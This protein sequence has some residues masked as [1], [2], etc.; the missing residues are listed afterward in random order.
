MPPRTSRSLDD[1]RQ[2]LVRQRLAAQ[3]LA[4][5]G[6]AAPEAVVGWFGAVQAQEYG[7]ARWALGQRLSGAYDDAALAA[8]FDDGRLL[9]T[10][11]LR[12]T[13]HFVTPSDLRWMLALTGPRIARAMAPYDRR[14]EIDE[15]LVGRACAV[16]E[17]TLAVAPHC[18]RAELA[19]ALAA[20]GIAASGQR[21]AHLV[22]HAELRAVVCSGPRRG[23]QFTYALVDQRVPQTERRDE[24]EA[25]ATLVQR[26]FQSHGPATAR[27]F[28]WWSG[29][30]IADATRMLAHLRASSLEV[31]GV[32]YWW[33]ESDTPPDH[34]GHAARAGRA[35]RTLVGAD[36]P[37]DQPAVRLLPIYDEYVVAYRD[38]T[39]VPHPS[40]TPTA[41]GSRSVVFQHALV[42]DGE[43]V[44]TWRTGTASGSSVDVHP[45]RRLSRDERPA[46]EAAVAR[47]AQFLGVPVKLRVTG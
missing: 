38:R 43:I 41:P 47:Y 12:P 35:G 29:L 26:Y 46:L 44:G 3:G 5:P 22:M 25:L 19:D 13:W 32:R 1:Q 42:I 18:T 21:L 23:R 15:A 7:P 2:R 36:R 6:F 9:R 16:F 33:I 31:N 8:A 34:A 45:V 27:D 20:A 24:D 40:A 17:R 28:A 11:V 14:M 37:T 4:A 39:L 30:R 10:H